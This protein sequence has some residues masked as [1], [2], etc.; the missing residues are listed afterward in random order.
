MNK[1]DL[2]QS[3]VD[4]NG[5]LKKYLSTHS[6]KRIF[7]GSTLGVIGFILSPVSWWNDLIV[8][9]PLAYAFAWIVTL[10]LS[11]IFEFSRAGFAIWLGIGYWITNVLGF[12]MMHLGIKEL[13]QKQGH[14][15]WDLLIST[16]YT[17]AVIILA[18]Y[19]FTQPIADVLHIVP[20]WV[21]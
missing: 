20:S 14:W 10:A 13:T 2:D 17:I 16:A 15:K 9:V 12:W 21:Q 19:G 8:N 6:L 1:N 18:Y 4:G 11:P 7:K 5:S 3:Q